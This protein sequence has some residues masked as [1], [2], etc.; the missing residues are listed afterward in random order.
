[1]L[2]STSRQFVLYGGTAIALHLGH[3]QSV[4]FDFFTS[5]P[6][7]PDILYNKTL[8]LKNATITQ[9][10]K[11]ALSVVT[12]PGVR[13][14]FFYVKLNQVERPKVVFENKLK[15]AS[16]L[17]L[18]GMKCVTVFRRLEAKDYIDIDAIIQY[19]IPLE[20][21]V[22]AGRAIY[23]P[24]YYDYSKT[25][26][27][28]KD[29]GSLKMQNHVKKRLL[30]HANSFDKKKMVNLKAGGKIGRSMGLKK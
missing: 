15:V 8:Y 11:G 17:D 20:K 28:L 10:T 4:D 12:K 26:L 13:V 21:G 25:I 3:R 24:Q 7:D 6:F 29:T 27:A 14:S 1:M 2:R 22:S 9:Q 18:F 16:I 30:E 23:H 5:E 19:G